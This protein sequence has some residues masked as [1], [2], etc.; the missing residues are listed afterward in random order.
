MN[1][2]RIRIFSLPFYNFVLNAKTPPPKAMPCELKTIGDHVRAARVSRGLE[3]REVASLLGVTE[4]TVWNWEDGRSSPPIHRCQT[5]IEF[6]GYHPFPRPRTF[7]EELVSFRRLKGLR[8][9]DAAILAKVNPA[10]WSSWERDEHRITVRC[11]DRI[12]TLLHS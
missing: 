4:S 10:S 3:Q 11:R 7:A 12:H 1:H 9:R 6:I 8:V 2:S 5:V